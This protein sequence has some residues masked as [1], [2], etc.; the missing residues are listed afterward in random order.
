MDYENMLLKDPTAFDNQTKYLRTKR[1][2]SNNLT[3]T[4][5]P[6]AQPRQFGSKASRRQN[7]INSNLDIEG[8]FPKPRHIGKT[9][10]EDLLNLEPPQNAP[11]KFKPVEKKVETVLLYFYNNARV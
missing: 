6:G 2:V 4:D 3:T 5:I 1:L 8:A 10:V 7:F 11:V 9:T